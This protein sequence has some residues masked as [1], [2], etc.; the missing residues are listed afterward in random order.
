[1]AV[2]VGVGVVAG[3]T[4]VDSVKKLLPGLGSI[5]EAKAEAVLL[6]VPATV[7]VTTR[8]TVALPEFGKSPRVQ[9]IALVPLQLP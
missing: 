6:S 1:M 5:A 9:L 4:V 8:V 3:R 2:G 7:G